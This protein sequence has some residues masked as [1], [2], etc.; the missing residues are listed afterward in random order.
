MFRVLL[1]P[2]MLGLH[3]LA[4]VATTAA[5]LLGLWQYHA[6]QDR[7]D[8]AAHDLTHRPP[9][10]LTSVM[11]SDDP[12]PGDAVGQP[13]T[14][15]GR[16]VPSSTLYVSGRRLHGARGYWA[17]TP[18]AVCPRGVTGPD[19][20]R[21]PAMLVVRGW[22]RTV[23]A[24][25]AAP[26]GD[27]DVTGWLQPAEGTGVVDRDP[28]DDVLPQL[29]IADAIQ[30]VEQ[31][32]YGAYVIAQHVA[33][34]AGTGAAGAVDAAGALRPVTPASLPQPETFTALRNL[35]YA[36]EWW[37]FGGFAVF[38]WWRWC[39]DEVRRSRGEEPRG[40]RGRPTGGGPG[41]D[42]GSGSVD[43]QGAGVP[44]SP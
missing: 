32:L 44:S 16:W 29:R 12:F 37:A 15:T 31:D 40:S 10:P 38:L 27:V 42:A 17:V 25:P 39:D 19:C 20:A 24:A 8:T 36:L 1:S 2:R 43:E 4:V 18:V 21:R 23:A 7:R 34:A 41:G 14:F 33:P 9:K 13:V 3:L 5:V 26:H 30:H 35:L 28:H 6:W 22:S 11:S